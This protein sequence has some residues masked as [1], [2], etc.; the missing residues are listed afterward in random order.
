M[1]YGIACDMP[2]RPNFSAVKLEKTLHLYAGYTTC[3]VKI[4][5]TG[6]RTLVKQN[7]VIPCCF[8]K[9]LDD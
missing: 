2:Y 1:A 5:C 9:D 3:R 8:T 7:M 4:C 6:S